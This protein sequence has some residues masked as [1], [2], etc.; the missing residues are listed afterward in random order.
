MGRDF[1][2]DA[3][4]CSDPKAGMIGNRHVMFTAA[5]R[6]EPHVTARLPSDRVP[7]AL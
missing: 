6:G 2:Q 5:L 4:E 1:V 3:P 7:V